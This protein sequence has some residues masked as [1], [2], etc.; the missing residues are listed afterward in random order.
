MIRALA[1]ASLFAL[2]ACSGDTSGAPTSEPLA[3]PTADLSTPAPGVDT[4]WPDP[5]TDTTPAAR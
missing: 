1:L 4:G 3:T 2:C 5:D